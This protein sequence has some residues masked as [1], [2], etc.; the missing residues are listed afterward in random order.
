MLTTSFIKHTWHVNKSR[1][2]NVVV[3]TLWNQQADDFDEAKYA[4]MEQPVIVV[5]SSCYLKT[6][7]GDSSTYHMSCYFI[8]PNKLS[9]TVSAMQHMSDPVVNNFGNLLLLQ[10]PIEEASEL[11]VA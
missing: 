4:Q 1:R 9:L 8:Q 11:L 10:P 2:N 3:F 6:Y 5:V 7:G